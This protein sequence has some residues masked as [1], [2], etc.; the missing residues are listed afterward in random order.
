LRA[1]CDT[2]G[3]DFDRIVRSAD[4]NV[5]IRPTE[6]GAQSAV[7]AIEAR[8]ARFIGD[9]RAANW[10]TDYRNGV[11]MVGTPQQIIDRLGEL[12]DLGLAYSI[13]NFPDVAYDT[14]SRDLFET[15]VMPALS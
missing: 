11:N 6:A 7:D 2:V 12:R 9:D 10:T 13:A 8:Y 15:E 4:Y 3:T 1:H 14:T 5:V